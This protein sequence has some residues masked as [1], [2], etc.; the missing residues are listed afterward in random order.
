MRVQIPD[1]ASGV[2]LGE[3][4]IQQDSL[5]YASSADGQ[6]VMAALSDGIGGAPNGEIASDVIISEALAYMKAHMDALQT[7][8]T[9]PATLLGDAVAKANAAI[10]QLVFAKPALK[11]MGGTLCLL[12]RIRGKLFWASVGDSFIYLC[13]DHELQL[14][15]KIH[16]VGQGLDQLAQMGRID[17][18]MARKIAMR[19]TLTSAVT[20][21]KI[22][23]ID[24]PE[25]GLRLRRGD[26]VVLASDGLQSLIDAGELSALVSRDQSAAQM[27]HDILSRSDSLARSG[28]DN[29]SVLILK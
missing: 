24:C 20:G 23:K 29:L 6:I 3:R 5:S 27:T 2:S 14:L 17:E 13:R 15:N 1:I 21:E 7:G 12:I 10:A 9:R 26:L 11:G 18:S 16:S 28:Q 22:A 8:R 19:H 25:D 4:R